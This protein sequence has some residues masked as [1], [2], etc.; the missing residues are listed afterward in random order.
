MRT[1]RVDKIIS[2][3]MVV[4][5]LL[6][7]LISVNAETISS[8][9]GSGKSKVTAD[10]EPAIF[11]ATVPY[12]L[13]ISV[14]ADN[15][16]SVADNAQIVNNAN[17]PINVVGAE[18]ST[19]NGWELVDSSVNFK[20][21]PVNSKQIKLEVMNTSLNPSGSV[22]TSLFDT[23][24]GQSAIS[25]TY[26][27]ETATQ[28]NAIDGV[29]VANALF[30]VEWDELFMSKATVSKSKLSSFLDSTAVSFQRTQESLNIDDVRFD[31]KY[32]KIDDDTTDYSIYAWIDGKNNAYWWTDAVTAYLPEYSGFLFYFRTNLTSID[33]TGFNTSNVTNMMGMFQDCSKL[34][35]LDLSEF[36]TSKVTDMSQLFDSCKKLTSLDVSNFNTSNVTDMSHMFSGCSKLTSLDLSNF[37]TSDVTKMNNMFY[38]CSNLTS[39]DVSNFDTSKVTEMGHMFNG[40][41]N[42]TS[43]DV[44][45]FDTSDVT[46]MGYMFNSCSK[47]KTIYVSEFDTSRVSYSSLM[48]NNCTS[49]VGGNGTK[50]NSSYIDKTYARID[51]GDTPG[52]FTYKAA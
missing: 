32:T 46:G 22:D 38:N 11:S 26:D 45:N 44:S 30:T 31:S 15:N 14:D 51:T 33:L 5:M 37:D 43:L 3:F 25:L 16:V 47:L 49:L 10:I 6:G 34:T 13:P 21:V 52:Y 40:C 4:I 18:I 24:D 2:L 39:L 19:N 23:I 7:T 36:N 41:S 9:Q 27:A 1:K 28:S 20:S 29:N 12:V 35:S 8:P 17:G 42:L 48:F 50:Y